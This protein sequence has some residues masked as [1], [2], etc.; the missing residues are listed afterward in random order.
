MEF[1]DVYS[2]PTLGLTLNYMNPVLSLHQISLK[3]F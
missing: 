1:E 2:N 3:M